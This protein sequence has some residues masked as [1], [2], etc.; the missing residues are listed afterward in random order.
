MASMGV[1]RTSRSWTFLLG[2]CRRSPRPWLAP[3]SSWRTADH[4]LSETVSQ[5][6]IVVARDG[7]ARILD[8]LLLAQELPPDLGLGRRREPAWAPAVVGNLEVLRV[9]PAP[10][11]QCIG[12]G[13]ADLQG[14]PNPC[15]AQHVLQTGDKGN[16]LCLVMNRSCACP[17][18]P[19]RQSPGEIQG[20]FANN[21][22]LVFPRRKTA[23]STDN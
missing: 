3:R 6:A 23:S 10:V 8:Q 18:A 22:Q 16:L 2:L 9:R 1:V 5:G 14:T 21:H 13:S 17:L 15:P 19:S 11:Q 20:A 7:Q 4:H 12:P